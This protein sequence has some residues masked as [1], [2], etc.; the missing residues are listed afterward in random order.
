MGAAAANET[1]SLKPN[2]K[3]L[4]CLIVFI[5]QNKTNKDNKT[6]CCLLFVV[7]CLLFVVVPRRPYYKITILSENGDARGHARPCQIKY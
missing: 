6:I 3:F 5:M 2:Q 1:A 4:S 7:C